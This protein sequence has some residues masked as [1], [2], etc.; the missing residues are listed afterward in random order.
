LQKRPIVL[1][2]LLTKATSYVTRQLSTQ[3]VMSMCCVNVLNVLWQCAVSMCYVTRQLSTLCAM[4]KHQCAM[5]KVSSLPNA[6]CQCAP[7]AMSAVSSLLNVLCRLTFENFYSRLPPG[8]NMHVQIVK[9]QKFSKVSFLLMCY[10][11][12]LW[13]AN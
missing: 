7:C 5:S 1:S 13:D 2:I 3:C 10:V 6:P 8:L 12:P 4:S 9:S 11:R